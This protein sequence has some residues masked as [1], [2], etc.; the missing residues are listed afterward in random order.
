LWSRPRARSLARSALTE[1]TK[2]HLGIYEEDALAA[3][4]QKLTADS[5]SRDAAGLADASFASIP[6]PVRKPSPC[7][8]PRDTIRTA[9]RPAETQE[10]PLQRTPPPLDATVLS[11]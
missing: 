1:K 5:E 8:G 2:G 9:N 11:S 6:V 3:I 10:P 4:A 7:F